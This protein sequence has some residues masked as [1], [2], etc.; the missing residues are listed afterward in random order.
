MK[1][2]NFKSKAYFTQSGQRAKPIYAILRNAVISV[3]PFTGI[4]F[5]KDADSF[6]MEIKISSG[7]HFQVHNKLQRLLEC[8]ESELSVIKGLKYGALETIVVELEVTE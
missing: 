2:I 3:N 7:Y 4:R 6:L 1:Q 5:S 8:M